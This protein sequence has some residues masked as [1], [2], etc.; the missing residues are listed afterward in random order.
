MFMPYSWPK[1]TISGN[2]SKTLWTGLPISLSRGPRNPLKKSIAQHIQVPNVLKPK[3]KNPITR[4]K[5]MEFW[6]KLVKVVMKVFPKKKKTFF[7]KQERKTDKQ[8]DGFLIK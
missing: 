3:S 4:L 8:W 6:I 2:G 1:E 7:L 5:W